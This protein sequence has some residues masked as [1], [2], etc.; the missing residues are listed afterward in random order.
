MEPQDKTAIHCWLSFNPAYARDA[1][2][3]N[4]KYSIE[5]GWPVFI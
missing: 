5:L 3:H 2:T 1:L 4:F